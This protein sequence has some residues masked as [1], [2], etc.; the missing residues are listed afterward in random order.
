VEYH[1]NGLVTNKIPLFNRLHW[2]LVSGTNGLYIDDGRKYIEVFGGL[3][4]IFKV[5]RVDIVCGF[6]GGGQPVYGL[7]I[8]LGG[9]VGGPIRSGVQSRD[10]DTGSD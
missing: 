3:E 10:Y 9:L 2:N 4:N 8:G 7:R 6:P 5:L 1:L